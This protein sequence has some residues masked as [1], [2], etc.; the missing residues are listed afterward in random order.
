MD[1]LDELYGR[2]ALADAVVNMLSKEDDPRAPDAL[3]HYKG[4]R[5]QIVRKIQACNPQP[6]VVQA[7][8]ATMGA[9]GV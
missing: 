5:E 7:N 9:K 2:K 4:Q 6:V 8:V 1:E 3:E